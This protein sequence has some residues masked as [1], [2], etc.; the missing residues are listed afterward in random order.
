MGLL[1][2]RLTGALSA[3]T[4]L[5]PCRSSPCS[6]VAQCSVS[7][8]GQ[9]ECRC[10]ENYYGDGTVCLP[11]DPCI[12]NNGGCPSNST[13]CLYWRPGQVSWGPGLGLPHSSP[14]GKSW[15]SQEFSCLICKMGSG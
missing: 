9:A 11:Q 2:T 4:A 1:G 5:D 13:L 8:R 7:P 15:A 10:P 6:T 12:T 3:L 14:L